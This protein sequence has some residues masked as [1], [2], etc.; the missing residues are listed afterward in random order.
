MEFSLDTLEE[1]RKIGKA[2]D[3]AYYFYFSE[4]LRKIFYK[5]YEEPEL[6]VVTL[7]RNL[8]QTL[9]S[10]KYDD[11]HTECTPCLACPERNMLFTG[12][13]E[14]I[15]V[16]DIE[17]DVELSKL[18]VNGS[19]RHMRFSPNKSKLLVSTYDNSSKK[20]EFYVFE[21]MPT[22]RSLHHI[23]GYGL[24]HNTLDSQEMD[25]LHMVHLSPEKKKTVRTFDY[26]T[27]TVSSSLYDFTKE[28]GGI[29]QIAV[30]KD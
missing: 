10:V 16:Y 6:T 15:R 27:K 1:K 30:D 7:A 14:N 21:L 18:G 23:D 29:A 24:F 17:S 26:E 22:S 5:N 19:V 8:K 4:K 12:G 3:E 11:V 2:L 28:D 20:T 9:K 25:V 13:V